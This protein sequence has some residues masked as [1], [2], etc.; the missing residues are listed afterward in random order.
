MI[1]F[2]MPKTLKV[3]ES[4]E[5]ANSYYEKFVL[6]PMERGY[7]V[8]IGNALRRVLLSSIPSMAITKL[9]IPNKYHEYDV[10]EGVKEDVLEIILNLKKVQLKP[11]LEFSD[12]VKL[13]IDKR[14]PGVLTAG[15]IRTP[16]GVEVVNPSQYIATLNE[17]AEIYMEL[18]AEIGKGFVPVSEM[19]VE[20]D[21]EMIYIDGIFSP[22]LKVNFISE[23]VRVGKKTDYDK[24]ILEVWT[25][26]SIKPS[27]ALLKATDILMKHFEVVSSSLGQEPQTIES[28]LG[29]SELLVSEE[30]RSEEVTEEPETDSILSKRIE[31][32]ELSVRS[33]NCLKRDKINTIGDLV[34][35]SEADLLKI[36]NFG[37]K[38]ME[39]VKKQLK[40]KFNL[41]LKKE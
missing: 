13:V 39:E 40:E 41:T 35:R 5:E 12:P 11:A 20:Q 15:D 24:L 14:G 2:V 3:E 33:L 27:E 7:A 21:V 37:E 23:N 34:N 38:S 22:V 16:T 31:E 10:I 17:E 25:K 18:F 28:F 4:R 19:E 9:K 8:T 32:L 30:I 6:S 26:K 29:D 36:R 1:G